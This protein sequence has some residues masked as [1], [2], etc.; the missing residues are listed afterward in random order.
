M[1]ETSVNYD[2][3]LSKTIHFRGDKTVSLKTT[4]HEKANITVIL[5]AGQINIYNE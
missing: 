2:N 5:A 3:C 1:D 4:G